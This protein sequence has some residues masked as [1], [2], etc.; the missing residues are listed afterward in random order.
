MTWS[1]FCDAMQRL[2][3]GWIN[4]DT[5]IIW[6]DSNI[7]SPAEIDEP[8]CEQEEGQEVHGAQEARVWEDV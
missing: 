4:C 8:G 6:I 5:G 3:T 2:Q 7:L 1:K